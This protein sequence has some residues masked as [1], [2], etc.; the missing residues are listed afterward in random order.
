LNID[1]QI[2]RKINFFHLGRATIPGSPGIPPSKGKSKALND[3]QAKQE[4]SR[5]VIFTGLVD[6]GIQALP[7]FLLL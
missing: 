5:G 2:L 6:P 1:P 3:E 4:G 7:L